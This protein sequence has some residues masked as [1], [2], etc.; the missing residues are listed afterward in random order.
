LSFEKPKAPAF[1]S[2]NTIQLR[3]SCLQSKPTGKDPKV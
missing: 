1:A 3:T 2:G